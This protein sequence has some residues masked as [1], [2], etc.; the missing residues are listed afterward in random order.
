MWNLEATATHRNLNGAQTAY[1]PESWLPLLE[2]A[3]R[4]ARYNVQSL[5]A[6]THLKLCKCDEDE[7]G[8]SSLPPSGFRA[9]SQGLLFPISLRRASECVLIPACPG[10][11][12]LATYSDKQNQDPFPLEPVR[13]LFP[14]ST[15]CRPEFERIHLLPKPGCL[16]SF[17]QTLREESTKRRLCNFITASLPSAFKAKHGLSLFK[18]WPTP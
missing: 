6:D 18:E 8:I 5:H 4:Y 17:S 13:Q 10:T 2:L 14:R 15:W 12:P 11:S 3:S 1:I 9:L 7:A 16:D